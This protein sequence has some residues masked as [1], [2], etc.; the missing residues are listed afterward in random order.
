METVLRESL[1]NALGNYL[2]FLLGFQLRDGDEM[3][4]SQVYEDIQKSKHVRLP[5]TEKFKRVASVHG[6]F[7]NDIELVPLRRSAFIRLGIT[8]E[9]KTGITIGSN[10]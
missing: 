2:E 6:E 8:V 1:I 7:K 4:A 5:S 3:R 10:W 9:T